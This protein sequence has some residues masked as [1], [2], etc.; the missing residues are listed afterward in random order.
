MDPNPNPTEPGVVV[1][2]ASLGGVEALGALVAGLPA[3]LPAA[4]CVVQ[5]LPPEADSRLPAI[6]GRAGPLPVAHPRDGEAMAPGRVY[7]AP[8]GRHLEVRPGVLA[9]TDGPRENGSRPAA[10]VLFRSA[11]RHYGPRAVGVVLT[12]SLDDGSAGLVAIRAVGGVGVVQDPADAACP[13]MPLSAIAAAAPEHVLPLAAIAACVAGLVGRVPASVPA[14]APGRPPAESGPDGPLVFGCPECGGP[15]LEGRGGQEVGLR[16]KVGH[17][18]APQ[19]LLAAQGEQ[20]EGA[21]WTAV[22]ALEERAEL[23]GRLRD[24]AL[25]GGSRL[26][27]PRYAENAAEAR[28]QADLIRRLLL[29]ELVSAHAAD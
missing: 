15:L 21:L 23:A 3:D 1:V 19:A 11:A 10:D 7:V 9:L 12:G 25:A 13:D 26:M 27:A 2:G 24:R 16:C 8:P 20:V 5:H 22:R 4:V 18:Y 17:A 28:G 6:L 29:G 14:S